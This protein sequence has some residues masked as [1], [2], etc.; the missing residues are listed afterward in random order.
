MATANK[1]Q[2]GTLVWVEADK[3]DLWDDEVGEVVSASFCEYE[4]PRTGETSKDGLLVKLKIGNTKQVFPNHRLRLF[5]EEDNKGQSTE[6]NAEPQDSRRRST[7]TSL[8]R[9]VTPSPTNTK[10]K[11]EASSTSESSSD[12]DVTSEETSQNARKRKPTKAKPTKTSTSTAKAK[13]K[14]TPATKKAKTAVPDKVVSASKKKE[15]EDNPKLI[16]LKKPA[17]KK[18]KAAPNKSA[19]KKPKK[20][21]DSLFMAP[22]SDSDDEKDRPFRVEYATT[23]RATCKGCDE[24]ITKGCLRVASRPLFRGK[25]GFVVYR[26]LTCQTFPEEI[27]KISDVGGWRRLS[28]ED[29]G[30]LEKQIEVSALRIEEEAK[31]LDADE[32]VQ[33]SFQGKLRD[34]PPGLS[35]T[36]LPFQREGTSWMY[37][38]ERCEVAGGILADEMGMGKTLQTI[39]AILDNRPK[40]QHSKPKAKHPPSAL[41]LKERQREEGLW[42]KA[43]KG[44]LNDL[45]MAD[46]PEQMIAAHKKKKGSSAPIG[47]RGGTL[48]VCPLIALYQWKEEIEKFTEPNSL[49]IGI[50]HGNDRNEKFPRE[51]LSKYDIVLTTYQVLEAD[52]RKMVSPNKVKCP[53]CGRAFK[54]DK[55][56]VHLKYFCGETAQRTEAQ[57]RQRRSADHHQRRGGNNSKA[58]NSKKKKPKT[59]TTTKKKTFSKTK[60]IVR[61][62]KTKGY[63]SDSDLSLP[64]NFDVTTKRPS[65]SAAKVAS[66]R[67][68]ASSKEWG[69]GGATSDSDGFSSDDLSSD[70]ESSDQSSAPMCT[71]IP[72]KRRGKVKNE[73]SDDSS[74]DS[75]S[76]AEH[77]SAVIRSRK[78]QEA[79]MSMVKKGMKKG[80][81]SKKGKMGK[82]KTFGKKKKFKDEPSDDDSSDDSS[83]DDNG[84]PLDKIDMQ[85]LKD[86]AMA[87][88]RLSVLHSIAWWRIVLD[89]AH[90]I[91]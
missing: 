2:A 88:C 89:E 90:N 70:D 68:S 50:Y 20:E 36:L 77:R 5:G 1:F 82:G 24:L 58:S 86:E 73:E 27:E 9:N 91:K 49:T 39:T 34:P 59:M 26:H 52:F 35:A 71:V 8:P 3:I 22:E 28:Q 61:A 46:V 62:K 69:A 79:A 63:E 31:E 48:V 81:V 25:P 12:P 80:M 56:G 14:A 23:G 11:V 45:R 66:K 78:R 17:A 10:V 15:S 32:L 72:T 51:I 43:L 67:L 33:A 65:R 29:R 76:E 40:L 47:V 54:I 4:N 38:Q 57:S 84:D 42:D 55:L 64:D 7:R 83:D 85:A 21:Q 18:R 37:N 53:N 19:A 13:K 74:S 41:D 87:G 30:V 16:T 6:K 44:C 75:D 60:K